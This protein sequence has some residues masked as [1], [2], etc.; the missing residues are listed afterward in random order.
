[1]I[2]IFMPV[3]PCQDNTNNLYGNYFSFKIDRGTDSLELMIQKA[4]LP[5]LT[6]PD[7]AQPT[8]LGT[9]IPVPSMTV[10]YEPL[11]VEFLVDS[12]LENWKSIYSWIRDITNIQ[13][14]DDYDLTYQSWHHTASLILHPTIS[15]DTPNPVLTVSF[16]NIIPVRL[17]GLIFQADVSDVPILKASC[18]F[19]YSHYE[20]NPDAPSEL[21]DNYSS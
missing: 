7:Q 20:L 18:T 8:I 5:G 16:A 19:K 17:T 2:N 1:V 9:T 15:C 10:Q 13:N 12:N 14:A 4:N 21:G 6:V 3:N 11:T